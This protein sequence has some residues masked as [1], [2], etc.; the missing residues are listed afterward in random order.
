MRQRSIAAYLILSLVTFLAASALLADGTL[1]GTVAGRV[2]DQDGKALPGATVELESVEKGF[3]RS[4][5][6]DA[7][8]AFT[9]PLLQPGLY[10]VRVSLAGFQSFEA[11]ET[12]VSAD[13]TTSISSTLRLAAAAEAITVTGEAPMVDKTNTSA[14][15]NIQSELTQ[16]LTVGRSYQSL[17]TFAPGVTSANASGNPNSHGALNTQNLYLFDGVDTTDVTTGTFGQNFNYEAI[18]EVAV[19]TSGIS[20]EYGR[21]QGAIINVI[22]KSG[23]NQFHGSFKAL[24]SNDDWNAQNKGSNP[25][26]GASFERTKLDDVINTYAATGGGPLWTDRA[27]FFGAYEWQTS[28]TPPRQTLESQVFPDQSGQNY[29]QTTKTRLWDGKLSGQITPS[30]LLVAQFNSDPIT[31]FVVDY[32]GAS[33]NIDALTLQGQN[34]CPG[35]GCLMQLR[36]S[37]VFGSRV[38]AEAGWAQQNGNITVVPLQGFG[39]PFFSIADELYWNGATFDGLVERPRTQGNVALSVYHELFG[40]SAQFKGGVDYQRLKSF[41]SFTYP[42]NQQ[43]IVNEF[44]PN[45]GPDNQNFAVG[46]EYWVFTDPEP[47]VSRGKI[48]GFYGLE[49]FEVGR[50]ALNLGVR[51][52]H[53]TG[54]SDIGNLVIDTTDA[55]PRLSAAWDVT[56]DGKTLVSAGYGRYYQFLVQNIVDSVFSG[57]PQQFNKDIFVWDGSQFVFSESIRAAA[58]N[59][60]VNEGLKPSYSDEFNIAFQRQIGSTMA[61]GI[62]GIYRKWND[63]T[64][65]VKFFD[66][67]GDVIQTPQ[68]FSDQFV[69]RSYKGIELTFEKRFSSNWQTLVNYTLG[70]AY[71]NQFP[72]TGGFNSYLFDFPEETCAPAGVAPMPCPEAAGNNQYGVSPFDRTSILNAFVAYTW[73]TPFVNLTGAPSLL[74]QSGLPYQRQRTFGEP[75]GVRPNYF[76]DKRGSSRLPTMYAVNFALEAMFKP[77]GT[78]GFGLVGGPIELGLKGE[79]FNL[80]NQQN[81]FR[82]D[83][84]Q[85]APSEGEVGGLDGAIFGAPTSRDANQAPRSYRF[86][87]MLRF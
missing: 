77:F 56:G 44:N 32:W 62:R 20:A 33:A 24:V 72:G 51:I 27:W 49:K 61:V 50:L 37:G 82:T 11:R 25:Q 81:T 46:D 8:G 34:D 54:D 36:W 38:T 31:G 48:Y 68:N 23:T 15:T 42:T 29:I 60:P 7:S 74:L 52:D 47:S 17:L 84:I 14:T 6:S 83:R 66:A 26:T 4:V 1:L 30:H 65:D 39:T 9:F 43:Y 41:S 22:T 85:L 86:T 57:V 73:S 12:V 69:K 13:K 71:G 45:L 58:A 2:L 59:Q 10:T 16:K 53:Q 70:R 21:A 55:A 19:S 80:T 75:D 79:V 78:G 28:S 40:N 18:Q 76:Y 63:I 5:V 67:A 3:Q 87:A 35:L 64:D